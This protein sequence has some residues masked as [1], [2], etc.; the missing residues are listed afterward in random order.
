KFIPIGI[1]HALI[2]YAMSRLGVY[3]MTEVFTGVK[4]QIE[5]I[6]QTRSQLSSLII[7][8][9]LFFLIAPAEEIFWR[10]FVQHR[11][12]AKLGSWRGTILTVTLYASVHIWAMN[13]MLLLAAA[14]LGVHWGIVYRRFG[15]LIPGIISHALWDTAIFVIL[16]VTF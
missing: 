8:P 13:P 12:M 2:L 5:A 15:S 6:Y 9:L 14:V 10:G 16:P 3:L 7:A 4:P 11:M 1:G